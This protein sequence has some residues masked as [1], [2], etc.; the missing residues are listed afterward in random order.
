[1]LALIR[2]R[3]MPWVHAAAP[4]NSQL[5]YLYGHSYGGLFTLYALATQPPARQRPTSAASAAT[6]ATMATARLP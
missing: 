2:H 6:Q 1:M 4:V 5:Q 3:I